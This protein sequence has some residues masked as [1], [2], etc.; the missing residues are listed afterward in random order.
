MIIPPSQLAIAKPSVKSAVT[1]GRIGIGPLTPL[2]RISNGLQAVAT[3]PLAELTI[4]DVGGMV[5]PRAG[6]ELKERGFDMFRET[7]IREASG[8]VSNVFLAGWVGALLLL[9]H[10][11]KIFNN[12]VIRSNK[13]GIHSGAW[14][15]AQ[16]LDHYGK[17]FEIALKEG[18]S[19]DDIRK[20]FL[21]R[22]FSNIQASDRHQASQSYQAALKVIGKESGLRATENLVKH[23]ENGRLSQEMVA[24]LVERYTPSASSDALTVNIYKKLAKKRY[25]ILKESDFKKSVDRLV[26][27]RPK[28]LIDG[29]AQLSYLTEQPERAFAQEYLLNKRLTSERI[30][31]SKAGIKGSKA[32]FSNK[33]KAGHPKNQLKPQLLD[34]GLSEVIHLLDKNGDTVVKNKNLMA[35][36]KEVKYFLEQY[37][38][39]VLHDPETG[40]LLTK[41]AIETKYGSIEK[42]KEVVT[43]KLYGNH[44][45]GW[46]KNWFVHRLDGLITGTQK[47]KKSFVL[48][49]MVL[50]IGLG[51]SVAFLN[52]RLTRKK[53]HGKNFF[54]GEKALEDQLN[55][56]SVDKNISENKGGPTG[57]EQ[58]NA[59]PSNAKEGVSNPPA[60]L[61]KPFY[62]SLSRSSLIAFPQQFTPA[63]AQPVQK[64]SPDF[65][66]PKSYEVKSFKPLQ[67]PV[68]RWPVASRPPGG[69]AR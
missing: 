38:D 16:S 55:G 63:T 26:E 39:R 56:N 48:T 65:L 8:T 52:N 67:Y 35:M 58:F 3:N 62:P 24:T 51:A 11:G 28:W 18:L 4:S 29:A 60:K 69:Q 15:Q 21:K 57:L 42:F 5:I 22:L 64:M 50:T 6:I 47:M 37:V 45:K 40:E 1:F 30:K 44:R 66:I 20:D 53:H 31:A 25:A 9:L 7:L 54:P 33:V 43:N 32:L 36:M 61:Q 41:D 68:Y 27:K 46:F 49:T 13:M 19:P 23:L 17:V 34:A 2:D 14:I 10:Q 12:G 59:A